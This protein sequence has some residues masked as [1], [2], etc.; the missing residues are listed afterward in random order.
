MKM[1]MIQKNYKA[2]SLCA[3]FIVV[4]CLVIALTRPGYAGI[5]NNFGKSLNGQWLSQYE[6]QRVKIT[7]VEAPKHVANDLKKTMYLDLIEA[8]P[9]GVV[10]G[11]RPQRTVFFPYYQIMSIEPIYNRR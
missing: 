6:G 7:F 3:G 4:I 11:L 5:N 10:I 8:G 1:R 9:T 2:I